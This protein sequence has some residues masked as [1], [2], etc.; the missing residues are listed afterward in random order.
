VWQGWETFIHCWDENNRQTEQKNVS[1]KHCFAPR[2]PQ[3]G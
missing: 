2:V 1:R 3:L